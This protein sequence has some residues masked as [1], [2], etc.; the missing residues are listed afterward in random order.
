MKHKI[1]CFNNGGSDRCYEA[2]AIGDDGYVLAGHICSRPAYMPNDLGIT[3]TLKHNHYNAHFGEDNWELEWVDDPYKH[4]GLNAAIELSKT[5][6]E[7]EHKAVA[8]KLNS[9]YDVITMNPS[10]EP[11]PTPDSPPGQSDTPRTDAEFVYIKRPD[12]KPERWVPYDFSRTLERELSATNEELECTKQLLKSRTEEFETER[13]NGITADLE[14][15]HW[16]KEMTAAKAERDQWRDV[17]RELAKIADH[18]EDVCYDACDAGFV[19]QCGLTEAL[20]KFDK[21]N[22]P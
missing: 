6:T 20:T 21:L 18:S 1:Y 8:D 19:C 13:S 16:R 7:A 17:A 4:D 15:E 14:A 5:H 2:M 3:S 9:N 12:L 22:N 10:T 11:M